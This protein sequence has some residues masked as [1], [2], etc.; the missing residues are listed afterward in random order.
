[1]EIHIV[2][3]DCKGK[4]KGKV[5]IKKIHFFGFIFFLLEKRRMAEKTV[6]S[7]AQWRV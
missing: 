5:W 3:E 4:K 1:M 6:A 7:A 2:M